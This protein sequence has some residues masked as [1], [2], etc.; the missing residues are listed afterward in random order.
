MTWEYREEYAKLLDKLS[1]DTKPWIDVKVKAVPV[2]GSKVYF[3]LSEDW[4]GETQFD[5]G[6]WDDYTTR[7]WYTED[8]LEGE[9]NTEFGNLD[10]EILAWKYV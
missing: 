8:S 4:K 3:K 10:Y 2:D 1:K 5:V 9:F 6:Y 7:W